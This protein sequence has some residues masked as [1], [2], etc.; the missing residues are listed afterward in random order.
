MVI[1][2]VQV[3]YKYVTGTVQHS[4]GVDD[5]T[6]GVEDRTPTCSGIPL[7]GIEVILRL[8]SGQSMAALDCL[9]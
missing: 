6:G 9:R 5:R 4:K 7:G 1:G 2:G 8:E 3:V